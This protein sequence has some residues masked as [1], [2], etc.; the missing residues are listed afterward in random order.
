MALGTEII[1]T[2][3]LEPDKQNI[4]EEAEKEIRIFE[5]RFSRFLADNELSELNNSSA[6]KHKVSSL[7]AELLLA[8]KQYNLLTNGI[9]EPTIISSLE[10]VGYNRSFD[11]INPE[12]E[13]EKNRIIDLEKIQIKY[14]NQPK[15][16]DLKIEDDTV[17]KPDGLRLDFGGIGKGYII[18]I[19]S[20]TLFSSVESYWISA[21]GDIFA[22]GSQ[23]N[24]KGWDI[25]VQNP[26]IPD[27]NIFS[28]NT[29][30]EKIGV[31]TSG[32]IKR[33]GSAQNF[34]WHH[35]I[36]PRSG[37]PAI[38]DILSVTAIS[39]SATRADIFAKT[40]LILGE[41]MGLEFIERQSDS[42]VVIFRKDKKPAF[43]SRAELY[44]N[45]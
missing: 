26:L 18:D 27:E 4:L 34:T 28:I 10:A 16:A 43:S 39:S 33:K 7:M 31:A 20:K 17:E 6:G 13:K 36:D 8:S 5:K 23:E 22:S 11:K 45:A 40:V 42:A 12:D 24:K 41:K 29:K 19:L 3:S 35:I 30:G 9:F 38:N 25:G 44:I 1:I 14:K 32:I 37:L 21:G 15:I 2:A